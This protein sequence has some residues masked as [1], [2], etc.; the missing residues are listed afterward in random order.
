LFFLPFD[1]GREYGT[2]AR[3]QV[4][5]TIDT[6]PYTGTLLPNGEGGHFMV[7]KKEIRD[8]IGKQS[9]D[10]VSVTM[11]LDSSPRSV[12]IPRDLKRAMEGVEGAKAAFNAMTYSHENAYVDWIEEAKREAT[13][14]DRIK[15]ALRM[16][17]D[18][19]TL[20]R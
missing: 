13:R 3:V 18:K 15:K 2:K 19:R 5:G 1:A 7:V 4:R 16:I 9:G 14:A 17:L 10:T 11:G 6:V 8:A 12:S 20:K